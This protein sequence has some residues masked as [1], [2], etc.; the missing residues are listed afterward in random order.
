LPAPYLYILIAGILALFGLMRFTGDMMTDLW[1]EWHRV[2][3]G[4][5]WRYL[6]RAP[7]DGTFLGNI[8]VQWIKLL[9]VPCGVSGL[10]LL[11]RLR[12]S[13]G[14]AAPWRSA[15]TNHLLEAD[16]HWRYPAIQALYIIGLLVA[17]TVM[18]LEKSSH[19]LGLRM[20]GQ[21]IGEQ[22]WLNHTL[23]V[24]SAIAGWRYM[25]WLRFIRS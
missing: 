23:H 17:F 5:F 15:N 4:T 3:D 24:I 2:L 20:A 9:S 21:L 25:R 22:A 7:S 18:E 1:P 14:A 8:S 16:R 13:N 11:N 19:F 10:F 12:Y 6:V